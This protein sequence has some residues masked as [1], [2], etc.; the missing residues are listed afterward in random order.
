MYIVKYSE[1]VHIARMHELANILRYTFNNL[2]IIYP[3]NG[4]FTIDSAPIY[5]IDNPAFQL[6]LVNVKTIISSALA[7]YFCSPETPPIGEK[8]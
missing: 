7:G 6:A 1:R 3:L 4:Y 5:N 2:F 8:W